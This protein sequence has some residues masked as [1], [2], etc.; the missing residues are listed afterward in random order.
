MDGRMA[1]SN[2][3]GEVATIN[4]VT[5]KQIPSVLGVAA[6]LKQLHQIKELPMYVTA[7][8]NNEQM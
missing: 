1:V 4:V 8:W 2:L 7:H 5:Q 6:N 3:N